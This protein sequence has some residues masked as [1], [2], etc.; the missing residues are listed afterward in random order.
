MRLAVSDRA[1]RARSGA[2][3]RLGRMTTMELPYSPR[4]IGSRGWFGGRGNAAKGEDRCLISRVASAGWCGRQIAGGDMTGA[5]VLCGNS[6]QFPVRP[7]EFPV[8]PKTI[9][10]YCDNYFLQPIEFSSE[11]R[12]RRVKFAVVS[13]LYGNSGDA[14]IVNGAASRRNRSGRVHPPLPLANREGGRPRAPPP[15][16]RTF[17]AQVMRLENCTVVAR[18]R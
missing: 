2:W 8:K 17:G 16:P 18:A 1:W 13:R 11:S 7:K 5:C 14:E 15:Q 12:G 3:Y 4:I 9:P 6:R 10:G